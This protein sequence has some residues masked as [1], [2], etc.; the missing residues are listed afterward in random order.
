[1]SHFSTITGSNGFK[2][3]ALHL[4]YTPEGSDSAFLAVR[5]KQYRPDFKLRVG[6]YVE[7]EIQL[8]YQL[9]LTAAR[10]KKGTAQ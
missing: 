1:M 10:L 8:S 2:W 4:P 7:G 6:D 9:K 5:N 3:T